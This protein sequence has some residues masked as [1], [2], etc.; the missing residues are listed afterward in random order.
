M[1]N[2]SIFVFW[3]IGIAFVLWTLYGF[4]DYILDLYIDLRNKMTT[5]LQAERNIHI[6]IKHKKEIDEYLKIE[7]LTNNEKK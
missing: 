4:F 6:Y 7:R 5:V 2:I 1:T 3:L